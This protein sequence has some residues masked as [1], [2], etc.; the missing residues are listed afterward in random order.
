MMANP[1]AVEKDGMT[2]FA[3]EGGDGTKYDVHVT[4]TGMVRDTDTIF[5]S[6]DAMMDDKESL[7]NRRTASPR[8][9]SGWVPV[10]STSCRTAKRQ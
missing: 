9:P 3:G 8:E 1:A 6:A 7:Y 5:Y 10:P 2:F 4:V